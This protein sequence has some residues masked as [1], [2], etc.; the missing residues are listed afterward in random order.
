MVGYKDS[1]DNLEH[2]LAVLERTRGKDV[3]VFIGKELLLSQALQSGANGIIVSLLFAEPEPFLSLVRNFASGNR[4][5]AAENQA[6]IAKLVE[7]FV[8]VSES[9][10]FSRTDPQSRALK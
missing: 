8:G 1:S 7:E 9:A 10:R 5:A 6:L 4:S 2:H 3:S